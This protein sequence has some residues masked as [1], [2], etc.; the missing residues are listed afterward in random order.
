MHLSF[1]ILPIKRVIEAYCKKTLKAYPYDLAHVKII[2][3]GKLLRY[4]KNIKT[5]AVL[6]TGATIQEIVLY[7]VDS[8][9]EDGF[10]NCNEYWGSYKELGKMSY[11]EFDYIDK[12]QYLIDDSLKI[13]NLLNVKNVIKF[14]ENPTNKYVYIYK[15]RYRKK[16]LHNWYVKMAL[17]KNIYSSYIKFKNMISKQVDITSLVFYDNECLHWSWKINC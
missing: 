5:I 3:K 2:D 12:F 1:I 11:A 8:D 17:G 4:W 7:L 16:E 13:L 15:W 10:R 14:P 6:K 9:E